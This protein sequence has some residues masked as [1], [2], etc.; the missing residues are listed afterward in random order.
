MRKPSNKLYF[1]ASEWSSGR[2]SLGQCHGMRSVT[3]KWWPWWLNRNAD[4]RSPP[5]QLYLVDL[6]QALQNMWSSWEHVGIRYCIP[7]LILGRFLNPKLILSNFGSPWACGWVSCWS[8]SPWLRLLMFASYII[9][10]QASNAACNSVTEALIFFCILQCLPV[11]NSV[12]EALN[13]LIILQDLLVGRQV[14][15]AYQKRT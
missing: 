11:C 3:G 14:L 5:K 10:R 1:A 15:C 13:F 4:Q 7:I 2:C 9:R 8:V 12:I 6:S